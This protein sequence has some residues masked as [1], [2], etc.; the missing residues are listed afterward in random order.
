MH[1][2]DAHELTSCL[3]LIGMYLSNQ[4]NGKEEELLPKVTIHSTVTPVSRHRQ[5]YISRAKNKTNLC[6]FPVGG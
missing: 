2:V 4:V 5:K 3:I 6:A 1:S